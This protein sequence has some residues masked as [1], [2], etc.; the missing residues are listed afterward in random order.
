MKTKGICGCGYE[1]KPS[2]KEVY[3]TCPECGDN[4]NWDFEVVN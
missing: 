1:K 3:S 2:T 4:S